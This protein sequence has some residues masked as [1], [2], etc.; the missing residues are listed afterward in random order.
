MTRD[1]VVELILKSEG[2]LNENEPASV[3]G[4][5]YAGVTQKAYDAYLPRI[6]LDIPNA[7]DSVRDLETRPAIVHKFYDMYLETYHVWLL[8]EFLQFIYADFVVNAGA[9][10]VKI[11]QKM[12]GVDADGV[13]GS[14]T[15]AAVFQWQREVEAQVAKDPSIDNDLIL[16]FHN[17]KLDHYDRLV[18]AN[19]DKFGKWLKGWQRRAL[20]VLAE[21]KEYFETDE[22]TPS[23]MHD[24]DVPDIQVVEPPKSNA[25]NAGTQPET[26]EDTVVNLQRQINDLVVKVDS[27]LN[28][29]FEG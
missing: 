9:A 13:F 29:K 19:P 17:A 6:R 14:G 7:P 12:A 15:K 11:I 18:A 3:G 22:G 2:G 25:W 4:I 26:L 24:A 20:D 8:P 21:L 5:S 1:N 10:A 27:L 23:A 16:E 28:R